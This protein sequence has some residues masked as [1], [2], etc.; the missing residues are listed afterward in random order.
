ML[1]LFLVFRS[2]GAEIPAGTSLQIRLTTALSSQTTKAKDKVQATLIAPVLVDNTV[3]L[4]AGDTLNGA[5]TEVQPA[6]ESN[7]QASLTLSFTSIQA[8][9]TS[10]KLSAEVLG[11][12][13]ARET[14]EG[15]GK[16]LGINSSTAITSQIDQG[17][18]KLGEK[19]A[20]FAGVL[21]T[22]KNALVK[23][24]DPNI[25]YD[26]GTEM[27][28]RLTKALTVKDTP[29]TPGFAPFPNQQSLEEMV[30]HQSFQTYAQSPARPS[31]ITNL[32]FIGTKE[33]L[34][35][36]FQ[37]AG[38]SSATNLSGSTKFE[39]ARAI[40]EQRGYKEAPVSVLTLDGAPPDLVFQKSNNTFAA[41]HH[42]RIWHSA[43]TYQNQE[44]WV[45]SS[46]HDTGIDFSEKNR[47][48]IHKIDSNIDAERTKVVDD[49][50]FAGAVRS[51]VLIDRPEVPK[52]AMNA[53]GDD[54]LTDGKMA[55]LLLQ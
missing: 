13:N 2:V 55:V 28:L 45:C 43:D 47:T 19:Y 53:T 38:W 24:V 6:T 3:A 33:Q 52:H 7:P 1:L 30:N 49:L 31:D 35:N 27:T 40:I 8:G 16:I 18:R 46:T 34:E 14:V 4:A 17:L 20:G 9:K 22:A 25:S 42:L 54:I 51:F 10:L 29:S 48:F 44:V 41:R 50:S 26:V 11:V 23:D 12:D 36:A 32:M 39:T 21:E 5:V 37:K 15:S